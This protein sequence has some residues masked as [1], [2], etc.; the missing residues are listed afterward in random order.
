MKQLRRVALGLATIGFLAG[1]GLLAQ[2]RQ[3]AGSRM[4][5]AAQAFLGMLDD[6]QRAAA[7]FPYDS[8]ERANWHFVPRQDNN[9][10][11]I[12]KGLPLE[13]M[14]AE[15]KTAALAI[16]RAALS[17]GGFESATTIMSFESLLK[18]LEVGGAMVRNPGWYFVS[19]FG[20]PARGGKWGFR[21]E[22]HHLSVNFT[23]DGGKIISTTPSVFG[24][25]PAIVMAGPRKGEKPIYEVDQLAKDLISSLSEDQKKIAFQDKQFPEIEALTKGPK[26]EKPVGLTLKQ[27]EPNQRALFLKLVSSYANRMP[28]DVAAKNMASVTGAPSDQVYFGYAGKFE[29]GEPHTYRVQGPTFLIEFLNT[30]ADSAKNPANHIHSGWRTL[31]GDFG[32]SE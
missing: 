22:G 18:E 15:Q 7:T 29:K 21:V 6:K 23:L 25:N 8:P 12:R 20:E 30:Q 1:V 26:T 9:K 14:T 31:S 17:P 28:D 5:S 10:K 13:N 24:S 19:L 11:S 27:L 32:L 16:L 3:P 4:A 2:E